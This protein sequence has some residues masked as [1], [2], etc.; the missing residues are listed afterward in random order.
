M[1]MTDA[2]RSV[3]MRRGVDATR[4]C[5]LVGC[6]RPITLVRYKG[7]DGEFCSNQCL[8]KSL[9]ISYSGSQP[10]KEELNNMATKTKSAKKPAKAKA[11][12]ASAN[13]TGGG[14]KIAGKYRPGSSMAVYLER[15]SDEKPHTIEELSE[16]LAIK[17]PADPPF[18][19][20]KRGA[21]EKLWKIEYDRES[22]TY[23]MT[24]TAK[25]KKLLGK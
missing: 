3:W 4:K 18:Y 13:G 9:G 12:A 6:G 2:E 16:G 20:K 25:G 19:L 1:L 23:T 14:E 10:T 17:Y 24:L 21:E 8:E 15:L 22:K 5:D 7:R 11:A